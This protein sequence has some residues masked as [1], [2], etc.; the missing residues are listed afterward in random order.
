M[1]KL[2]RYKNQALVLIILSLLITLVILRLGISSVLD[3]QKDL[4]YIELSPS[5]NSSN[6]EAS[7]R[8]ARI[9]QFLMIGDEY[10]VQDLYVTSLR[11][12]PLHSA[13][14]LGLTET[15]IE[16]GE[17][18][19]ARITLLRALELIPSSIGFL[20][21][22]SLLAFSLGDV[23]LALD[24]LRVV[25]Q[26]DPW[27]R[28]S[29]FDLCGQIVSD[30][31]LIL[32]KVV[33]DE[34][35]G[36]YLK[37]LI[38]ADK[39]HET[40]S[41]WERLEARGKITPEF[42]LPYVDYLLRKGD[43]ENAKTV[44]TVLYPG[45]GNNSL[46]WNGSF[47]VDS[48]GR[49]LD[50]RIGRPEGVDIDFDY[51]NKTRGDRSM[52]ITFVGKNNIDFHH[53]S[54]AVPVDPNSNYL[55]TSDISTRDITTRNGIRWEVYCNKGMNEFSETYTGTIDWTTARISFVT[56]HDCNVIHVR[57]RRIKSRK[58]D[59]LISGEAWIDNV[60]LLK[61]GEATDV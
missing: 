26:A 34:I 16:S 8:L 18:D 36:D 40:Y 31:N 42:T 37:Y 25:A 28:K 20:W 9:Y 51:S 27:R 17:E 29:V 59:N 32:E 45:L 13:S 50:W 41:V 3:N 11:H 49:G 21:E 54:Q 43:S 15:Y 46:V 53:V 10:Q 22:S 30:P 55:L 19:K 2:S 12:N 4:K 23:D 52:K 44:W 39:Q 57:L 61:L 48:I 33:T 24:N 14:W 47:E 35:L 38:R 58:L 7:Y 1:K 5:F 6:A 60:N 56:P